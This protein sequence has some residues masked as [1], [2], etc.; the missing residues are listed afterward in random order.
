VRFAPVLRYEPEIA[1][2]LMAGDVVITMY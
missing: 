2:M 1:D